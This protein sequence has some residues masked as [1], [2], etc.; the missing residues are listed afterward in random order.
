MS[1]KSVWN[2]VLQSWSKCNRLSSICSSFYL[3]LERT[4][5]DVIVIKRKI[6]VSENDI[7]GVNTWFFGFISGSEGAVSVVNEMNRNFSS[8][9]V[10]DI[11]INWLSTALQF[12]AL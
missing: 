10:T 4:V 6:F 1:W 11:N 7:N 9:R 3:D 8:F 5:S 12:L 2:A